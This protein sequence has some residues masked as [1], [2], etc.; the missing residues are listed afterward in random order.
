MGTT[1][2]DSRKTV[3]EGSAKNASDW[4][5]KAGRG[6]SRR[7][8]RQL[9]GRLAAPLFI[10]PER[11]VGKLSLDLTHD[12][13]FVA[14]RIAGE[15]RKEKR[16]PPRLGLERPAFALLHVGAHELPHDLGGGLVF[17]LGPR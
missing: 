1:S 16:L 3:T 17:R 12:L 15:F 6:R 11:G 8:R 13:G 9:R 14:V 4:I 5:T 2:L 10:R 7:S